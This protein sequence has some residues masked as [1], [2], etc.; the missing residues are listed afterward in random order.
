ML[1]KF[2]RF[3]TFLAALLTSITISIFLPILVT[4]QELA[5]AL[6]SFDKF[7]YDLLPSI[8]QMENN[9]SSQMSIQAFIIIIFIVN[10]VSFLITSY[11]Q[12]LRYI[13]FL[14]VLQFVLLVILMIS[15][16]QF[17]VAAYIICLVANLVVI[18]LHFGIYQRTEKNFLKKIL[19]KYVNSSF[20]QKIID[21][22]SNIKKVQ[23][24]S[25]TVM[26]TDLRNFTTFAEKLSSE[27][28]QKFMNKYLTRM[29]R[30]I[31]NHNG[32]V[33]K[34]IGDAIMA[35][36]NGVRYDKFHS[37]QTVLAALNMVDTMQSKLS[38]TD[39][40]GIGIGIV[41]G[42]MTIGNIGDGVKFNLTIFGDD[43]NLAS[44]LEGLTKK[45][46]VSI[47]TNSTTYKHS[48]KMLK[49]VIWRKLDVVRVKGRQE[50]VVLYQPMKLSKDNIELVKSY[51]HAFGYYQKLEF[52]KAKEILQ[53]LRDKDTP[54]RLMFER[55][56]ELES[57]SELTDD[58]IVR[59]WDEK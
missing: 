8:L 15:T 2:K 26:F 18:L 24:K 59:S 50:S 17:L 16:Q 9:Y 20:V 58:D 48:K 57:K 7:S 39:G 36:W 21:D 38:T 54:S 44:R 34:Y 52:E 14:T 30:I 3:T 12:K 5:K 29:T 53:S 27:S 35:F 55:I 31:D 40:L 47:I 25:M 13:I 19:S 4:T 45:Y 11:F 33:D 28:L 23:S 22:P 43:V 42:E 56:G 41:T 51:E 10:L 32:V 1:Q 46:E 37:A 6:N 49:K